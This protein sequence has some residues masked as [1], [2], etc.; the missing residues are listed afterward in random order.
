[1]SG[2]G[3]AHNRHR[4]STRLIV[5]GCRDRAA[6]V[7]DTKRRTVHRAAAAMLFTMSFAIGAGTWLT[8]DA[9]ESASPSYDLWIRNGRVYDGTGAAPIQ[10]DVLVLDGRI[11]RIG[12][13]AAESAD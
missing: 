9:A 13:V 10:A 3:R 4:R 12:E 8:A 6:R 5:C 1:M 11:A 7:R 2:R